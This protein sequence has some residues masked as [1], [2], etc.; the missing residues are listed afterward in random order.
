MKG[1]Q[2]DMAASDSRS[3]ETLLLIRDIRQH[4][5]LEKKTSNVKAQ[6]E[7]DPLLVINQ[8]SLLDVPVGSAVWGAS[9]AQDRYVGTSGNSLCI[10]DANSHQLQ[11]T[12]TGH[13]GPALCVAW[14]ADGKRLLSGGSDNRVLIWNVLIGKVE[15]ELKGHTGHVHGV[16]WSADHSLAA[17]ASADKTV[18]LWDPEDG[19][20]VHFLQEHTA[21]VNAVC[22]SARRNHLA[23]SSSDCTIRIWNTTTGDVV[24]R[25]P[26][27]DESA[28]LAWS[29]DGKQLACGT[30]AGVINLWNAKTGELM[31]KLQGHLAG[32]VINALAFHGEF[33]ISGSNDRTIRVWDT[34]GRCAVLVGH[35][36]GVT[37]LALS[38]S[39]DFLLSAGPSDGPLRVWD[40]SAAWI[41]L[42]EAK[43]LT[44]IQQEVGCTGLH[45]AAANGHTAVV[46]A[47][48]ATGAELNAVDKMGW[49]ALHFAGANGH[50]ATVHALL[51][52]GADVNA[53]ENAGHS[54]FDLAIVAGASLQHF[55]ALEAAGARLSTHGWTALL[56]VRAWT[57]D[58]PDRLALVAMYAPL[59]VLGFPSPL[60]YLASLQPKDLL[61]A[62]GIRAQE[63]KQEQPETTDGQRG[64]AGSGNEDQQRAALLLKL[65]QAL[66]PMLE[67]HAEVRDRRGLS[68]LQALRQ[69]LV[70]A[71]RD[72]ALTVGTFLGRYLR[73]PAPIYESLTCQ[74][75]LAKDIKAAAGE[76][77][78]VALKL[79]KGRRARD[80]FDREVK[81][82]S[83]LQAQATDR[84]QSL[85][86]I[87]VGLLR[88][89]EEALCLVMPAAPASLNDFLRRRNLSG[90][91]PAAVRAIAKAV[92]QCVLGL[93]LCGMVHGD[94]KPNNVVTLDGAGK[95]A[96]I[97]F[98]ASAQ[99]GDE[100]GLKYSSA[101]CPPELASVIAQFPETSTPEARERLPR[102]AAA[103]DVFSF[104]VLLYELCTGEHIFP[105]VSDNIS[106]REHLEQLCVWLCVSD[107]QLRP[108]FQF[109]MLEQKDNKQLARE[110]SRTRK[111]AAHLI[112]WCLQSDPS[113]RPSMQEVL[114]HRFLCPDGGTPPPVPETWRGHSPVLRCTTVRMRLHAFISH[115]QAE[116]SGDVGSLSAA[117]RRCGIRVWRDMD[118]PDLSEEGMQ[119]GV[120]D[121]DIFILMLTNAVLS[122]TYCLKEIFWALGFG[123]P[124]IIVMETDGRFFCFDYERW[125]EDRLDKL[126]GAGGWGKSRNLGSTFR[127][128]L[129]KFSEVHEEVK[130][131]WLAT[132]RV[133]IPF[134]RRGF[135]VEAMVREI[136]SRAGG[137]GLL[138][139]QRLPPKPRL[140]PPLVLS[141][142]LPGTGTAAQPNNQFDERELSEGKE[143][144]LAPPA[145]PRWPRIFVVRAQSR[146]ARELA[147]ELAQGLQAS[148]GPGLEVSVQ[149]SDEA[150]V[151]AALR[152]AERVVV[153]LTAGVFIGPS[154]LHLRYA[155]QEAKPLFTVCSEEAGWQFNGPESRLAPQWL[156]EVVS[157]LEALAF[158]SQ[159]ERNFEF[160]AMCDELLLRMVSPFKKLAPLS[161]QQVAEAEREEARELEQQQRLQAEA[162]GTARG[163]PGEVP[164]VGGDMQRLQAELAQLKAKAEANA[165]LATELKASLKDAEL[166]KAKLEAE[167]KSRM[168]VEARAKAKLEADNTELRAQLLELQRAVAASPPAV[169]EAVLP[170][171]PS[172][173]SPSYSSSSSTS[174][175]S[176][177]EVRG[178]PSAAQRCH[179]F[180]STGSSASVVWRGSKCKECGRPK[181][182]H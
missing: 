13:T 10:F 175:P 147:V 121:C 89:H 116:A 138:W 170:S 152:E 164:R 111:D 98:D 172:S 75:W 55:L 101:Y 28:G 178:L 137:K 71:V 179:G 110:L 59:P 32:M 122:R 105:H 4:E 65:C 165:K 21:K 25:L 8:S 177:S 82:R 42:K 51:A 53:L 117:L 123:K 92:G 78:H 127:N 79:I 140:R 66:E 163:D 63:E 120:A 153:L 112:R 173:T 50:T 44:E 94:L 84:G 168:E 158:R 88:K 106:S 15:R 182:E 169:M 139:G 76:L 91:D 143:Q 124:F 52:A 43:L 130:R 107:E 54:V 171:E 103:F 58:A 47:L 174:S 90:R 60:H 156:M 115:M 132:P 38:P 23:S 95:W 85:A 30:K 104:G 22:F 34:D 141:A 57:Q 9:F 155:V 128:C 102:A 97:D 87:L 29:A 162:S 159:A 96:L 180:R 135:E 2:H 160:V 74:V 93:H 12:L 134:R 154:L 119:Q 37:S 6:R 33:L 100:V 131:Q 81:S 129:A 45:F 151:P 19:K 31:R 5:R 20:L 36:S 1:Q 16:A 150:P 11:Q 27:G 61:H 73:E 14:S 145:G 18:R 114:G 126:P 167:S 181:S 41:S 146:Q 108:L 26:Q 166:S 86:E 157:S 161:D 62:T 24:H 77:S 39:G 80:N 49:T 113:L 109:A 142:A 148:G 125:R 67:R 3:I 70:D 83:Y 176:A 133:T 64:T 72:W 69:S 46:Q 35:A 144:H 118:A 136:I 99:F 68:P 40:L 56:D 17:S 149:T 7:Q 48:L